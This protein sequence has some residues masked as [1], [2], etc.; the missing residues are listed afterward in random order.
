VQE[1][2]PDC[3][4]K[5]KEQEAYIDKELDERIEKLKLPI[6]ERFPT[7]PD[8]QVVKVNRVLSC[9]HPD[10]VVYEAFNIPLTVKDLESLQPRQWLNDEVRY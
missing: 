3:Y 5:L 1:T 9:T 8:D 6:F 10:K 7:L 4:R 2:V